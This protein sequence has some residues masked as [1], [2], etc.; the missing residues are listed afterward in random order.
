VGRRDQL[1]SGDIELD[2][3]VQTLM[4]MM[5]WTGYRIKEQEIAVKELEAF[6]Q[7]ET[8]KALPEGIRAALHSTKE[9]EAVQGLSGAS[10]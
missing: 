7:D 3:I 2:A 10:E 4:V 9:A 6:F 1:F 5:I 8:T